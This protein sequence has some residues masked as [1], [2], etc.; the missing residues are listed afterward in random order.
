[1]AKSGHLSSQRPQF[2]QEAA[3]AQQG[4]PAGSWVRAPAGQKAVQ[5][6]HFLHQ[7]L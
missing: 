4:Y 7:A 5:M 2:V 3:S 6:P 1:M